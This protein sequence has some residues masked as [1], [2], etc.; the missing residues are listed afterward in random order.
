[1][2]EFLVVLDNL[3]DTIVEADL[4]EEDTVSDLIGEIEIIANV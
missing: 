2:A 3:D 1:M 4:V